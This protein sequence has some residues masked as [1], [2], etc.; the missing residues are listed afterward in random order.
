MWEGQLGGGLDQV[1]PRVGSADEDKFK[2]LAM[3]QWLDQAGLA[4]QLDVECRETP[5]SPRKNDSLFHQPLTSISSSVSGEGW[6]KKSDSVHIKTTVKIE[7]E[8]YD[9]IMLFF[10]SELTRVSF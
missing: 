2:A 10:H 4:E 1:F 6:F 7:I 9:W 3:V 8:L 5:T